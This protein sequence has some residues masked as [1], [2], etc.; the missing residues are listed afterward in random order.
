MTLFLHGVGADGENREEMSKILFK[1]LKI[2][3]IHTDLYHCRVNQ[4][5]GDY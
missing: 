5:I 2:K 4:S 1:Q 3:N